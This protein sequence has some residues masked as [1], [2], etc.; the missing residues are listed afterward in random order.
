VCDVLTG[1]LSLSSFLSFFSLYSLLIL[2]LAC[3]S[4]IISSSLLLC[5][6]L[7]NSAKLLNTLVIVHFEL[8]HLVFHVL[9]LLHVASLH[10]LV[11]FDLFISLAFHLVLFPL[12]LGETLHIFL[13]LLFNFP[14]FAD[15]ASIKLILFILKI[16]VMDLFFTFDLF[17]R[18]YQ[19]LVDFLEVLGLFLS[20]LVHLITHVL[21]E[22]I[23]MLI[24]KCPKLILFFVLEF[25]AAFSER[26]RLLL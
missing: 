4:I 14:V 17:L 22:L 9:L 7:S 8:E 25:L 16:H 26:S 19:L 18:F 3:F 10:F 15:F 24:H 11:L 6:F 1:F 21:V 12:D 20:L 2:L 23:S 13:F 5:P